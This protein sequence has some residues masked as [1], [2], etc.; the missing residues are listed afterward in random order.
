MKSKAIING[1]IYTASDH[2]KIPFKLEKGTVLF[3]NG[4]ITAVGNDL[5]MPKDAEII[6]IAG[7]IMTPGL[8][9]AHCHIGVAEDGG[10]P[11]G[12]DSNE[13]SNPVTAQVRALDAINPKD[14]AFEDAIAAGVTSV[15]TDPGSANI[16]GGETLV[17]KTRGSTVADDLV[18]LAP[19]GIKAALGE[20]PKRVY[21]SQRKAPMTRMGNAAVMRNALFQAKDYLRKKEGSFENTDKI[22]DFDLGKESL[23]KV[24]KK[25]IP[26]R[27]HC[28][29]ADDII[30]ALRIAREFDINLSLEHCTEGDKIVQEVIDSGFPVTMGPSLTDKS[31]LEVKDIGFA[32]PVALSRAGVK[33]ALITDHPVFPLEYLRLCAG[34]AIREGMDEDLALL[35]IT[36]HAAEIAGVG[37]RIGSIEPG[38]DADFVVWT[39]DPFEYDSKVVFTFIAGEPVYKANS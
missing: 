20:N 14:V 4:K 30:T 32:A 23:A 29:R 36:R 12:R 24:L 26:L 21:G 18:I 22:P 7:K 37:D 17:M 34:L 39:K 27:V 3:C 19:S 2:P 28:H 16:I 13:A 8:I 33:L 31:K 6:D 10:T 35:A 1:L 38:K 25:E 15:Q 9:D 11:A 5:K